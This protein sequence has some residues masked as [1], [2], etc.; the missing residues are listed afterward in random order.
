MDA[1]EFP[2]QELG[3]GK[4]VG[5][6]HS[7]RPAGFGHL[8]AFLDGLDRLRSYEII[9]PKGVFRFTSFEEAQKWWDEQ[10]TVR[11]RAPQG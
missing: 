1:H 11:P 7:S 10:W 6:R 4:V 5:R 2:E 8:G 9:R 3:P